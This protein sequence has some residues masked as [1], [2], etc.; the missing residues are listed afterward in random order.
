VLALGAL[1]FASTLAC[2]TR[3]TLAR[4]I[5]LAVAAML[6]ALTLMFF[7]AQAPV[8]LV[9]GNPTQVPHPFVIPYQPNPA[10]VP[11]TPPFIDSF[12]FMA[13][14]AALGLLT[15]GI[16]FLPAPRRRVTGADAPEV[17]RQGS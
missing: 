6:L 10:L 9:V 14:A 11:G 12:W 16:A 1:I 15:T 5:V 7:R 3:T 8:D 17:A 4:R 13:P 2:A